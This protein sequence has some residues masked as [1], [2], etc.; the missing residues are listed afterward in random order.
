M[1]LNLLPDLILKEILSHLD[2]SYRFRLAAVN[3]GWHSVILPLLIESFDLNFT[4]D[5]DNKIML[6]ILKKY[7][8]FIK[9]LYVK[10]AMYLEYKEYLTNVKTI[11]F[12]L[13]EYLINIK[14]YKEFNVTMMDYKKSINN[15][16]LEDYTNKNNICFKELFKNITYFRAED[17]DDYLFDEIITTLPTTINEFCLISYIGYH[18][19]IIE[20]ILKNRTNLKR[21]SIYFDLIEYDLKKLLDKPFNLLVSLNIANQSYCN[22]E[23]ILNLNNLPQLKELYLYNNGDMTVKG[24]SQVT[25]IR[26]F[27][28][29]LQYIEISKVTFPKLRILSISFC[30]N[31]NDYKLYL[32]FNLPNLTNFELA[33]DIFCDPKLSLTYNHELKCSNLISLTITNVSITNLFLENL[34]TCYPILS[35]LCL[36]KCVFINE[37]NLNYN[38]ASNSP[39]KSSN[40]TNVSLSDC[41]GN[42]EQA[43]ELIVSNCPKIQVFNLYPNNEDYLDF[44]LS[45]EVKLKL[46]ELNDG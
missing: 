8:P 13:D 19:P 33:E 4:S 2:K 18:N 42:I 20:K 16:P 37:K 12:T 24:T 29:N 23:Y 28:Q 26:F 36:A 25:K 22:E 27:A 14:E 34:I 35:I 10:D 39:L 30:Q 32:I 7:G 44:N 46:L 17:I 43:I 21:L 40:L 5:E 3:K 1:Q 31:L 41:K 6:K 9:R 38:L 45:D 15:L 11:H